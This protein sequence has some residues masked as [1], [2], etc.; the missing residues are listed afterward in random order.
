MTSPSLGLGLPPAALSR[1][2]EINASGTWG[3]ALRV[4]EFAAIRSV[5]FE[6]AGQ[7]L[8][9]AVY[10]IGYEGTHVCPTYRVRT[11]GVAVTEFGYR[12]QGIYTAVS[13]SKGAN[14]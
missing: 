14:S 12:Q 3:S 4:V 8:G 13:G 9:A 1:L 7:V 5:G 11:E 6:P 2:A 10:K